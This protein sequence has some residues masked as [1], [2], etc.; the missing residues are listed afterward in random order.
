MSSSYLFCGWDT[1][2]P[3]AVSAPIPSLTASR[4]GNIF[5]IIFFYFLLILN[6]SEFKFSPKNTIK[7]HFIN[8]SDN[9]IEGVNFIRMDPDPVYPCL[10]FTHSLIHSQSHCIANIVCF[11]SF[12]IMTFRTLFLKIQ[13]FET[14]FTTAVFRLFIVYIK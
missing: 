3:A 13:I 14:S 2:F 12:K 11:I 8:Y 5:F 1:V 10:S 9:Y 7:Y 6:S 4:P